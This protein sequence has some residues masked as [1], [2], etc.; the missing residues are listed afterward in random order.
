MGRTLIILG[1]I[2]AFAV[3]GV[4][5][6]SG[7]T[8]L[9]GTVLD[10]NGK[11]LP[12]AT[13][14]LRNQNIAFKEQG[15]VTNTDGQ[16]RFSLLPPGSGYELTVSLP[17]L[18]TVVF[19]D[20]SL[21]P[22]KI[23]QQHVVLRPA[24]ELKETVRVKGKSETLDTE[25]VTGSTTFTSTFIAE[26][27]I[28][29]RD[30]QDIL[31]LAPGVTD[32]NG[33]GNPNIHGARSTDVVTLV[34]GVST[35]DPLTGFYGQNL[36][37]ESI[38]ELEVITS[39]A[40]AQY[41]R[42]QGGFASIQTKSG[43]N[44]FQGTFKLFLRSDRLDGDGA[45]VEDPELSGGLT[46]KSALLEQHF[47]DI[48][49]FLSVAGPIV[50]DHLWYY[51]AGEMIHEETPV[52]NVFEAYIQP[53]YGHR[54]FLKL[55]WQA[56]PSHRLSLSLINDYERRENQGVQTTDHLDS[57]YYL[58]RGGPTLTLRGSSVFTPDAML[59]S[60]LAWFDNRFQQLPTT[61]P[62]TNGNGMLYTDNRPDLGGNQNGILE[63]HERDPGEDWDRDRFYDVME[64]VNYDYTVEP[65]E[66]LDH[67]GDKNIAW[68]CEGYDHEDLNCDG[69]LD[70]EE[71]TNL[72]G[73]VDPEEDVGLY[74]YPGF[75]Y[76]PD[77]AAPGTAGNGR[78]DTEDRN[79]NGVLDVV[80]E[81]GYTSAPFWNDA[82]GNGVEEPGEYRQPLPPDL[83]LQ[84]DAE[85]RTYG[86]GRFQY[87]DHR[88]RISWL[89]DMS[90]YVGDLAG[91][92]DLKVG[93][94]Y[95]HEG[96][97]S[98]TVQ[99][100]LIFYPE[101]SL[102][103]RSTF[104]Y[105]PSDGRLYAD[106]LS[107]I[108]G[109]PSQVN[110][111]ATGDNLGLYLQDT[112]KPIP[113]L[114]VGLGV[115]FDYED[116]ESFG[117]TTFDPVQEG[118]EFRTLMES[119]GLDMNTLDTLSIPG[120]CSD[121]L[122]SCAAGTDLPLAQMMSRMRQMAF[123]RLTRHNLDVDVLSGLL[124][125]LTGGQNNLAGVFGYS[126]KTRAPESFRITNSNLAPRLSLTWDPWADGRTMLFG[127]WGRYY[128]KLFLGTAVLEQG[129][130]TVS[131][132]YQFDGDWVNDYYLPDNGFGN[133]LFGSPSSAYQIDRGLS[134]PH[135]DEF[136]AGF[137]RELA[138][139]VLVSLRYVNR[140]YHDQLQDIDLNHHTEINPATGKFTDLF[141]VADCDVRENHRTECTNLPNGAP[142]LYIYNLFFNRVMRL[143]N[144]N[145]QAY[146]GWELEF[147]RRLKRRW[148]MEASYTFSK[149]RGDA[150]SY[151]ST[152]GNDPA[153]AE[154]EPGYLNY[155]QTHVAKFSAIAF[156]PHDWRLGGTATWA[157]GLPYS[158]VV[159]YS[160]EDNVG[161]T[162][163]RL[164]YGRVTNRGYGFTQEARNT[165][166][167][168]PAYLFNTRVTK[169]FVM[170]KA[171][172]S[173][174]M[175]IYNLLNSDDLRVY[176]LENR[177]ATVSYFRNDPR[178]V[179][180]PAKVL[181]VGEREFG[182]R[183]QIGFQIDF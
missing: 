13:V 134:T 18:A 28:L 143:G 149:S 33:T 47:S 113:N 39:A 161:Y 74:C 111:T 164:L 137:R 133:P 54:E 4:P 49:P 127:S 79:G 91:T 72:N 182:R 43:G 135:S 29:G 166:R 110:N 67:D 60:S 131:R 75:L 156:L 158:N 95:E 17:G 99:R 32:V 176:Y 142:D 68:L 126:S 98:D 178:P 62:D 16:F 38:Q 160:D 94:V 103:K 77:G 165:H 174:F 46:G 5:C 83:D 86:P 80:G 112:W 109:L 9:V 138:P 78:F 35:T 82:N 44:E 140:K 85:G 117:Y 101:V 167:N 84:E 130:D 59:E 125:S 152:L 53:L 50:R 157:S 147:A 183:F 8:A 31:T 76:C 129:P 3:T 48:K 57:G 128:D 51:L 121:P 52:N 150:E 153:L 69:W 89:E 114:T 97:D 2:L 115:R 151:R 177:R 27:P 63:A 55:S 65:W 144:Y 70:F 106:R 105:G 146:E 1:A 71:D 180:V 119:S 124:A 37:I 88:K 118:H 87:Q 132:Q 163:S 7:D 26:L 173:A 66:D 41:S 45:G 19:S 15:T 116:I 181:L 122:H 24:G 170:G 42:A 168:A 148:Q 6:A 93:A 139:E 73:Q 136:T 34:D 40:T 155:D 172:A 23:L 159:H 108:Q 56:H 20:L 14:V 179:I 61:D 100:P 107:T 25:T 30:Y 12:G 21:D 104:S 169:S 11:P 36:N 162:Q 175:E 123:S 10:A 154:Y 58:S 64:D 81:S 120:L 145:E 92:H 141:G 90:L 171:A 22:G 102:S 96:Y